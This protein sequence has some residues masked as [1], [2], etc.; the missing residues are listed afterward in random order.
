MLSEMPTSRPKL[1]TVLGNLKILSTGVDV[2]KLAS[3]VPIVYT[4]SN[5]I[6]SVHCRDADKTLPFDFL[7]SSKFQIL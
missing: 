2:Y 5:K 1:K 3:I 6:R 7:V 4:F